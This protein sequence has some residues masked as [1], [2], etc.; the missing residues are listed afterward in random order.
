MHIISLTFDDG[1]LDSCVRLARVHEGFGLSACINPVAWGHKADFVSPDSG[2]GGV[3]KGDFDLW[4]ELASRGHEIMPHGLVHANK[5]SLRHQD[6]ANLILRNLETFEQEMPGFDRWRAVYNFPYNA[7]TPAI[8]AWLP[9]VVRAFRGGGCEHGINPMPTRETKAI[10]TTGFGPDNCEH[11]LDACITHLLARPDGWLVYNL[12][13]LD[14]EGWGPIS[15]TYLERLLD[16]LVKIPTVKVLPVARALLTAELPGIMGAV[17]A[18]P[19]PM[20]RLDAAGVR[21]IRPHLRDVPSFAFPEGFAIRPMR[22]HESGLWEDVQRDAE[23][24]ITIEPGLFSTQFGDDP[25]G[26]ERRCFFITGPD[27]CAVGTISAWYS[28]DFKGGDWGRIHWV[29][30][31]RGFQGLGLAKAGLSHA[32]KQLALRHDRA[33][34][35]TSTAR[36]G[37]IKIYLDFGFLPDLDAPWA[38][39]AWTALRQKLNHPAL[40]MLDHA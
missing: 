18:P 30:T 4:R 2:Q 32:M 16:R 35:D 36:V 24:F 40:A 9:G 17:P 38:R 1:F 23:P 27:G 12:H 20:P 21:M 22:R 3:A 7:T 25:D 29:A 28:R 15:T 5:A 26:I 19:P 8:E 6:A 10:R 34:L 14:R 31:R 11:H 33:W 39:E 37:A 13:G